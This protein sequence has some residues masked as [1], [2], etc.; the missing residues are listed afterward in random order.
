MVVSSQWS[1]D[2]VSKVSKDCG[3]E[4]KGRLY[5]TAD[6]DAGSAAVAGGVAAVAAAGELVML[7]VS[8]CW[9]R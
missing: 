1:V 3:I 6:G 8:C 2:Q 4:D 9:W 5:L 7:L